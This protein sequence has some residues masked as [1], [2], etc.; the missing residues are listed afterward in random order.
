MPPGHS[1]VFGAR[2]DPIRSAEGADGGA[3]QATLHHLSGKRAGEVPDNRKLSSLKA[4]YKKGKKEDPRNHRPVSLTSVLDKIL[5]QFIFSV[6]TGR[7][8]DNQ[9]IRPRQ[10]GF[11]KDRSCLTNL[12][13]FSNQVTSLVDEG[14]AVDVT[15]LDFRKAFDTV[16][17]S[18]LLEKLAAHGLDGCTLCCTKN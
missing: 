17:H 12:I 15:Y 16:P 2:W 13:S 1:Q 9:G 3:G 4:I 11:M 18:I 7:V 5:E 8:K 6:F 10:H 14:K